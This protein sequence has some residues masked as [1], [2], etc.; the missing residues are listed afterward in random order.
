MSYLDLTNSKE[1]REGFNKRDK[2]KLKELGVTN[3]ESNEVREEPLNNAENPEESVIDGSEKIDEDII[4]DSEKPDEVAGSEKIDDSVI[5]ASDR[6]DDDE[7]ADAD[8]DSEYVFFIKYL[9]Y[10]KIKQI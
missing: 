5:D 4:E 7:D 8:N 3:I 1:L 9:V 10:L 6:P 2:Q